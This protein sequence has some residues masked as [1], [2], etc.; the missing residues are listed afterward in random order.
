MPIASWFRCPWPIC[1]RS[2][3]SVPA[4]AIGRGLRRTSAGANLL[5]YLDAERR[6]QP[7]LGFLTPGLCATLVRPRA[8]TASYRAVVIAGDRLSPE[9]QTQAEA[10]YGQV[11][12]L[13]GSTEMGSSAPRRPVRRQPVGLV[14]RCLG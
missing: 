13:Y 2:W 10:C 7:T 5:R 11:N 6:F 8:S 4:G 12:N 14:R 3:C 1:V 9:L